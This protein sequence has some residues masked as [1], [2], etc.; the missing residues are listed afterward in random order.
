MK[1][2]WK[3][4]LTVP[5]LGLL[6]ACSTFTPVAENPTYNRVM[7]NKM[8]VVGMSGEQPPFNFK[9]GEKIVG[10][11]VDIASKLAKELGV[12]LK[13]ST[14]AFS[15]LQGALKRGEID[16][17]MSAFSI[18]EE[19]REDILFSTAYAVTGQSL[20]FNGVK[21]EKIRNTTG[22]NDK[23]VR[24]VAIK[25]S[26]AVEFSKIALEKSPVIVV[27][28]YD[29][30]IQ[31]IKDDKADAF[32]ADMA[33]C[34]IALLKDEQSELAMLR[35][36]LDIEKIAVA[37]NKNELMLKGKISTVIDELI[38]SKEILTIED[39][40]FKNPDWLSLIK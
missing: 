23:S 40:W 38:E 14:M 33:L 39:K 3:L 30:A 7:E 32:M 2:F 9:H 28:N 1:I 35:K 6:F 17:I 29:D 18:T 8:L 25:N 21:G 27:K 13:V 19:R 4:M 36:P 11:D 34:K 26:S 24:I 10:L 20:V 31:L 12:D 15:E 37:F 5:F 22:F 16:V